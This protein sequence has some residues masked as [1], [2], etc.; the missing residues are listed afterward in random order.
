MAFHG[1]ESGL[2]APPRS[3]SDLPAGGWPG[4][5]R[6]E[7][8]VRLS[9][10]KI[11]YLS[12]KILKALQDNRR[13]HLQANADLVLRSIQDAVYANM[14]AEEEIDAEVEQ[15]LAQHR[16]QIEAQDLDLSVL[17]LKLKRELARKRGF[18]L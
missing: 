18:T 7:A 2:P 1:T 10:N 3:R 16:G 17:R 14:Q 9:P 11:D 8:A 13:V 4:T 12:R 6:Q 5:G 15:L